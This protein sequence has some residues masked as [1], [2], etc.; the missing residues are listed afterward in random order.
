MDAHWLIDGSLAL[1]LLAL[2]GVL[3]PAVLVW[4]SGPCSRLRRLLWSLA[5]QLPWLFV[6]AYAWVSSARY[7]DPDAAMPP[8]SD[9]LGWWMLAFPWAVYLLYRATRRRF[10]GEPRSGKNKAGQPH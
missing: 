1:R 5:T 8:L 4:A 2:A 10:A 9:A 3:L 6:L 7:G